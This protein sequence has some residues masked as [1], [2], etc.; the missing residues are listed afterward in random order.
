MSK[1]DHTLL[2]SSMEAIKPDL[3][4]AK[5]GSGNYKTIS[6]AIAATK[7]IINGKNRFIIYIKGGIYKENIVVTN[8]MKN[9]MLIGDGIDVTIVSGNKNVQDGSTTFRSATFGKFYWLII[10]ILYI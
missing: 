9:L 8:K 2:E 1:A 10:I 7:K 4:V 3:V 5:D 6:E